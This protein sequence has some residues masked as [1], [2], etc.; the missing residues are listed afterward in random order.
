MANSSPV[1]SKVPGYGLQV[2]IW[3]LKG[4]DCGTM[5]CANLAAFLDIEHFFFK[6]ISFW[7]IADVMIVSGV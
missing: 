5:G 3:L 6:L 2:R 1:F 4:S 7:S